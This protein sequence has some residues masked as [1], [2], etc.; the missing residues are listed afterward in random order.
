MKA[1]Q[2]L[3]PTAKITY[4]SGDDTAVAAKL[5]ATSDVVI[6]FATQYMSESV[7]ARTLSL[8]DH[9]DA[10]ITA[11]AAANPHTVVVLEIGGP[12]SMPWLSNV[13]AVLT[14][15]YPGI[16][17]GEAIAD[18]LFGKA[19]PSGHLP[20]TFA[21]SE[22]NLP[23]PQIYGM[24]AENQAIEFGAGPEP[25]FDMSYQAGL[26][27]GYRWYELKHIQ[28][29]FAFGHGLS[30]T[31][32][33]YDDLKMNAAEHTIEFRLSNTGDVAGAEVA[34]VYVTL[35]KG[36]GEP[37]QRLAAWRRV[38]LA[39]GTSTIVSLPLDSNYISIFDEKSNQWK[40]LRGE[41]TV[42]V[43]GASD[44]ANLKAHIEMH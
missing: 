8:P 14:A 4:A 33:R 38:Q 22:A 31:T 40:L 24:K 19:N 3:A 29:L 25:D 27:V 9:Q 6:I 44:A 42:A 41:Y 30:Y 16:G 36:S 10:L 12:V 20:I 34:Q 28:P 35:P 5:A 7:D 17:G 15:W 21:K 23:E 32:F 37:F 26:A 13:S 11:V 2:K 43:G 18:L 39:P 1:I